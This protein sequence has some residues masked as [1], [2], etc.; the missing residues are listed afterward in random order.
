VT[1]RLKLACNRV[2]AYRNARVSRACASG[3]RSARTDERE[4]AFALPR[5]LVLI[6][7][8]SGSPLKDAGPSYFAATLA[9]RI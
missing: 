3:L 1:R 7:S 5:L 9:P 2:R 8:L 4:C 6:D